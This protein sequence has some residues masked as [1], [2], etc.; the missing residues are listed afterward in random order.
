LKNMAGVR[1]WR[2][3]WKRLQRR[4]N[5][6]AHCLRCLRCLNQD[7]QDSRILRI[8]TPQPRRRYHH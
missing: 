6:V 2:W 4:L 1:L 5:V 7:S 8:F 3:N